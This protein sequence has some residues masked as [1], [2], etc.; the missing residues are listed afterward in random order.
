MPNR[1]TSSLRVSTADLRAE[2]WY[3]PEDSLLDRKTT[4]AGIGY[5]VGWL[6]AVALTGGGPILTKLG[7]TVRYRK[8]DVLAWLKANS[9]RIRSTAE[10]DKGVSG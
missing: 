9:R 10:R 4:A 3:A 1:A 6:E 2:F 8:T 7:R 5:T